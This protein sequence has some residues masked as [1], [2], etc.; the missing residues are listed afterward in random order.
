MRSLKP[1]S[2]SPMSNSTFVYWTHV[3]LQDFKAQHGREVSSPGDIAP[4]EAEYQRYKEIK[5][6]LNRATAAATPRQQS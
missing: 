6:R 2:L 4:V 3:A 1:S 5:K